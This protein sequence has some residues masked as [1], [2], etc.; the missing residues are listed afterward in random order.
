MKA[1][2]EAVVQRADHWAGALIDAIDDAADVAEADRA[3]GEPDAQHPTGERQAQEN[4]E[5]DPPA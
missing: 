2:L 5:N 3:N 4:R 1:T